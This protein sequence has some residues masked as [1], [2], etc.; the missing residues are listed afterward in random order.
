MARARAWTAWP[1]AVVVAVAVAMLAPSATASVEIRDSETTALLQEFEKAQ[2]RAKKGKNPFLAFSLPANDL[3]TLSLY[4]QKA[5]WTGFGHTYDIFYGSGPVDLDVFGPGPGERY[6]NE[7]G[8][9]GTPPGV[10]GAGGIK[11]CPERQAVL[12]RRLRSQRCVLHQGRLDQ[13]LGQVPVPAPALSAQPLAGTGFAATGVA[14]P[15]A[16]P[17]RPRIRWRTLSSSL[18]GTS[19]IRTPSESMNPQIASTR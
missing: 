2:C 15:A 8:I 5:V 3:Y 13:R 4:V 16:R 6:S 10:V 11:V 12:D 7:F 18:T 19:P 14:A 9:P 17:T 1:A